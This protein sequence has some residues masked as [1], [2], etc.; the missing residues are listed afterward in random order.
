MGFLQTIFGVGVFG[1]IAFI[2]YWVGI[3]LGVG[4]SVT[5]EE[6]NNDPRI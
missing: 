2:I 5:E 1:I 3:V 4:T 6:I